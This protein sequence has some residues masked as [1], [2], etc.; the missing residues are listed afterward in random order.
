M[1]QAPTG[2]IHFMEIEGVI[3][4]VTANYLNRVLEEAAAQEARL[5]VL[6]VDTPGGLETSMRIMTRAI[7]SSPVPVAVYVAPSG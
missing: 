1:A 3:N 6:T 7:L 2:G 5:V 4:P